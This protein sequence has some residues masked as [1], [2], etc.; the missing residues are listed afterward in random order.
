MCLESSGVRK[1][2]TRTHLLYAPKLRS[3]SYTTRL[4]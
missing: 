2:Y 3:S 4:S 1:V